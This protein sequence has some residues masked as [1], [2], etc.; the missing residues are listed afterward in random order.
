M[1]AIEAGRRGRRVLLVDHAE[2]AGK[3]I[4]ISGGGRSNFTNLHCTPDNFL[5]RNPHFCQSALKRFTPANMVALVER[6]GI[7]Y[8]E[9]TLGQ[10]FC[11]RSARDLVQALERDCRE[12]GVKLSLGTRIDTVLRDEAGFRLS[13]SAGEIRCQ[14]LVVATGGAFDPQDGR[15][16][17]R[18]RA[19]PAVLACASWHP[20][21]GL[22]PLT[23]A[24]NDAA[25]WCDLSGV[26]AEVN[27]S[28]ADTRTPVFREKMLLTHRG[29][30]GPAILQISS[31]LNA[32]EATVELDLAPGREL[33]AP[34]RAPRARRD[35]AAVLAAVRTALP[36]RW[37]ERWTSIHLGPSPPRELTNRTIDAL[38]RELHAWTVTAAGTEG[39]ARAEVT[40]GG[41]E[42]DDLDSRTMQAR[43]VPGLYFI[44]EAVDVTGWLG[45][46]NFQWAWA[47]GYAAG[48]TA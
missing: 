2:A 10:L 46:Y 34:L 43:N 9:K 18:L 15:N 7:P 6:H 11:D 23:L 35:A 16:R 19:R 4:L 3:K 45:G 38:E 14:S 41:V 40:V 20:R 44:G 48:Q 36:G 42:T 13:S 8:H 22:V 25:H 26:S 27:A 5:S 1:C 39:F 12:A 21:P 28:A 33:F 37:A 47:S 31:Y 17:L 29:L 30:S 32:S 24:A